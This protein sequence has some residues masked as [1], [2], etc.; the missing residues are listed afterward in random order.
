MWIHLC[1]GQHLNPLT[2]HRSTSLFYSFCIHLRISIAEST[3]NKQTRKKRFHWKYFCQD[4]QW[5][6]IATHK[7][8]CSVLFFLDSYLL[9]QL[10]NTWQRRAGQR[11]RRKPAEHGVRV[12]H[13][14]V[15]LLPL[16]LLFLSHCPKSPFP[17]S[18][19]QTP[20]LC[21]PSFLNPGFFLSWLIISQSPHPHSNFQY[22]PYDELFPIRITSPDSLSWTSDR[23]PNVY[24]IY[25]LK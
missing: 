11:G 17:V 25:H 2:V 6:P 22:Y 10:K 15:F 1:G 5:G 21:R 14:P 13:I 19:L 7:L 8:Y 18:L 4:Y 23:N 20:A 24:G 3:K 12:P 16:W 9:E